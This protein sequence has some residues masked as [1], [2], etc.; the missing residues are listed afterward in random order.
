[1]GRESRYAAISPYQRQTHRLWMVG[2]LTI[3]VLGRL[4]AI[5]FAL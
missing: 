1:M 5:F 4:A 3:I 2:F